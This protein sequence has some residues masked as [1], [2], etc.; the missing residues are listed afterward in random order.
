[1]TKATCMPQK[2]DHTCTLD[3]SATVPGVNI[4]DYSPCFP[5]P[6]ISGLFFP[7]RPFALRH[8]PWVHRLGCHCLSEYPRRTHKQS[9][10]FSGRLRRPPEARS[11]AKLYGD[12]C[13]FIKSKRSAVTS[14]W[15]F[16][17]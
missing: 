7:G 12:S 17:S 6:L 13:F 1:M 9:K 15:H 16:L 4:T 8:G 10:R 3:K 11:V 5:G 2:P 14:L